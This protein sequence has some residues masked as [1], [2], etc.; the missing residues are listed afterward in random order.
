M[1]QS[2]KKVDILLTYIQTDI[3][4]GTTHFI[5]TITASLAPNEGSNKSTL[6]N[7]L[8]V[9]NQFDQIAQARLQL[10]DNHMQY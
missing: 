1:L 6:P 5:V 3:H 9:L 4:T 8:N 7:N 10:T 2:I